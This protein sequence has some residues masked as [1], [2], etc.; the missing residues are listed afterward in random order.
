MAEVED[1]ARAARPRAAST[2]S[3]SRSTTSQGASSAAGIE[4]PLHGAVGRRAPSPRRAGCASRGRSR[5]RRRRRARRAG[6]RCRCRSGSSATSTAPRI[7]ALHGATH[8]AVVRGRERPDPGVEQL[9]RRRRRRATFA[10]TYAANV[11]GEL[12][13]QRVPRR[14][15]GEHERLRARELAARPALDEVAGDRERP[16]A[17]ADDRLSRRAAP[18]RTSR[19]A[20]STGANASSGSG[21]RSR[22]TSASVRTGSSITGPTPSTS[23]TST[24]IPSTGVMMSANITAASTS[25]RRTGWSVTSAQSSGVW[26]TSKNAWRSRIARYSGSDRPAWR[27]NHTGRALDCLAPRGAD[28]KRLGHQRRVAPSCRP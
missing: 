4:V 13:Q 7:R 23:S 19:T 28:E 12:L 27:M 5:R 15:L 10:A 22:S 21:T 16:A 3:A 20:S 1:V 11:V 8:V 24:P 6:G 25:W 9:D 2:S 18:P 26:A 17:E 14:R